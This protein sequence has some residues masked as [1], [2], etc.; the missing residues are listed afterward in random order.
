MWLATELLE[1]PVDL[2]ALWIEGLATEDQHQWMGRAGKLLGD[3]HRE[4]FSHGDSK[5][6]NLLCSG[7]RLFLIDLEAVSPHRQRSSLLSKDL[8]RFILNGEDR[9]LDE[10]SFQVFVEYYLLHSGRAYEEMTQG[11]MPQLIKLRKRHEKQ[12]GL[13]GRK[14]L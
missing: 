7:D 5:W 13:R 8:A 12:Y 1:D 4:G 6:T 3:L 10:G 2:N 14:L 11:V 9:S